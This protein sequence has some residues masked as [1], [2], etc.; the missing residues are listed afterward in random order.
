M[1]HA[2]LGAESYNVTAMQMDNDGTVIGLYLQSGAN[3]LDTAKKVKRDYGPCC[4][5]F[6]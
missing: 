1:L 3:A 2:E 4:Q 5:I 6:S